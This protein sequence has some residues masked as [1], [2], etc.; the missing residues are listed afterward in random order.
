TNPPGDHPEWVSSVEAHAA[1]ARVFGRLNFVGMDRATVLWILG[2]PP[3]DFTGPWEAEVPDA[4]LVDRFDR[5]GKGSR[6]VLEF[7]GGRVSAVR[8][9]AIRGPVAGSG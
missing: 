2:E 9:E 6:Y 3:I 5:G 1:A 7:R 4:S 8:R